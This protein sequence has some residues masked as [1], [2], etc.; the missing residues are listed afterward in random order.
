M[1]WEVWLDWKLCWPSRGLG[2]AWLGW[3]GLE[4]WL[5]LENW[6]GWAGDLQILLGWVGCWVGLEIVWLGGDLAWLDTWLVFTLGCVG[7]L[8]GL[9]NWLG[10]AGVRDLV[11]DDLVEL[12]WAGDLVGL[13]N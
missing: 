2:R 6:L 3:A 7:D 8:A 10:W 12:G 9:K 4:V 5:H 1:D 11:D 13:E